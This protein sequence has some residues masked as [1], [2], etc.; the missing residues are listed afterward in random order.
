MNDQP[1]NASTPSEIM[2]YF[3]THPNLTLRELSNMTSRTIPYL[4]GLLMPPSSDPDAHK[5]PN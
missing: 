3:D 1:T 5:A 4:K 2:D